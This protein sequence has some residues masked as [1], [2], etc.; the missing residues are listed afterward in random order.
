MSQGALVV[1]VAG[2][3]FSI[4]SAVCSGLVLH[5]MDSLDRRLGHVESKLMGGNK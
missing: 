2:A 5:T 4:F 3:A 1:I